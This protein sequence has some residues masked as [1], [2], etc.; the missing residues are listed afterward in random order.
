MPYDPSW[1]QQYAQIQA[2]VSNIC[3]S[4]LAAI[5][6][7]GSTAVPG[8][9]AKPLIDVIPVLR[10]HDDGYDLWGPMEA[11]GYLAYGAFG[12]GGRHFFVKGD[13]P[14][15]NIHAY[16]QGHPAIAWHLAFRDM[17]R[18]DDALRDAYAALKRELAARYPN[19]VEAYAKAKDSFVDEA[20]AARGLTRP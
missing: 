10:R 11:A 8:L 18:A 3:G 9:D 17:L 13:P 1:P 20:L 2:E 7:V 14:A 4:A 19:D 12:I 6:H 5:H 15:A 16:P